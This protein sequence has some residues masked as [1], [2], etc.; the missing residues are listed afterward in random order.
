MGRDGRSVLKVSVSSI[1]IA[2][3][4]RGVVRWERL[5][6]K[7]TRAELKEAENTRPPTHSFESTLFCPLSDAASRV[8]FRGGRSGVA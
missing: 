6:L 1:Q 8:A 3:T 7:P 4:Y 2:F 5:Q